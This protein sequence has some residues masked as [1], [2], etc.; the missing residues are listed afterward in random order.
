MGKGIPFCHLINRKRSKGV[1]I[2][3]NE[4]VLNQKSTG[5]LMVIGGTST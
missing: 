2:C 3:N 5:K 4:A 1:A